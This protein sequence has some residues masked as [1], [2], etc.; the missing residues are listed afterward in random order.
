MTAWFKTLLPKLRGAVGKGYFP[1]EHELA[2]RAALLRP[3]LLV[4]GVGSVVYLFVGWVTPFQSQE[5]PTDAVFWLI[6]SVLSW[7][8]LRRENA[9]MA[10]VMYL[11]ITTQPL[12]YMTQSYGVASPLNGLYLVGILICG[13]L[14]GNWFVGV[15]TIWYGVWMV[16]AGVSELSGRWTPTGM[17]WLTAS[18]VQETSTLIGV[19]TFWWGLFIL[20]GWLVGLISRH[21]ERTVVVAHGQ[22]SALASTLSALTGMPDL[23]RFLGEAL[24]ATAEQLEVEWATL[25]FHHPETD[26]LSIRAGFGE[27]RLL[28]EHETETLGPPTTPADRVP[29][30]TEMVQ[31]RKPVAIYDL[32]NDPRI[33]N[34]ALILSQGLKSLLYVPLLLGDEIPGFLSI[35]SVKP[36]H[37]SPQEIELAQALAQQISLAIQLTRMG[38]QANQTILLRERNRIAREIHDT[39]A[40]GF[41]GI[42]IQLEAADDM[43]V[44]APHA[45]RD[46][47]ARARTLARESLAEARRSVWALRSEHAADLVSAL[48]HQAESLIV[49]TNFS[50]QVTQTG[51]PRLIHET[52]HQHLLRIGQESLTNALRHGQANQIGIR[53]SFLSEALELTI[54]DDGVG[55]DPA[56]PQDGFGLTGMRERAEEWGGTLNVESHLG[57]GTV[58]TA[59]FPT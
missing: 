6:A 18:P 46:H 48:R 28:S 58:V 17:G 50:V 49:G 33:L 59:R 35:N 47:L 24:S 26:I 25:I 45:A 40:Q 37:F 8:L 38:E 43:L 39:L 54:E 31:T 11:V 36:R 51:T 16:I 2:L 23:E 44:E 20:M 42:V 19:L 4:T 12:H 32:A 30:W 52:L 5:F 3:I 1:V 56:V 7:T 41:T 53:L 15:W 13:L 29:V 22:T 14:I 27:G 34:R 21:L 9:I 55:F 57:K 10:S